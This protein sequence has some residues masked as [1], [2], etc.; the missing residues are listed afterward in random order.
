MHATN[1]ARLQYEVEALREQL[2]QAQ[3]LATIG[4]MAAMVAHEFN[5]ILTP[6]INYAELAR[7]DPS[8][9]EKAIHHAAKGGQRATAICDVILGMTRDQDAGD[10]AVNLLDLV[11]EVFLILVRDPQ[12]DRIKMTVAID[13]DLVVP[14][15]HAALQQVLVNLIMNAHAALQKRDAPRLIHISACRNGKQVAIA[16]RDNGEGI[17]P[18]D[19]DKVFQP[20]YTTR[21]SKDSGQ[22]HGL[23]LA[24]CQDIVG[25]AG[26]EIGV[27]SRLGK[28]TTFTIR[29]PA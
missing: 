16:V 29:I 11:N 1:L 13:E 3:R 24:I 25:A 9:V 8:L 28:G 21:G 17:V 10:E 15:S 22:G 12:K 27:Q 20:F 19:L 18:E 26:W 6:I 2:R 4:R 14:A 5:N 7:K 23:G